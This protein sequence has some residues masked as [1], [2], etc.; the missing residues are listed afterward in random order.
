[1][2]DN[3]VNSIYEVAQIHELENIGAITGKEELLID[4]GFYTK[5]IPVD[6]II[7]YVVDS[8]ME[9]LDDE[10]QDYLNKVQGIID[11]QLQSKID[12]LLEKM[13][14]VEVQIG[15]KTYEIMTN[16]EIVDMFAK[17]FDNYNP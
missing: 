5:K 3:I 12:E 7:G 2:P 16:T 4:D 1:M 15:V 9:K 11:S 10:L 14:E 13:G 8:F 6:G 17:N